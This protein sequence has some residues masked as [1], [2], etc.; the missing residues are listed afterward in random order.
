[1]LSIFL[2]E[3][4]FIVRFLL[5]IRNLSELMSR[6]IIVLRLFCFII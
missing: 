6:A 3:Y 5:F 2:Y 1:M 4:F